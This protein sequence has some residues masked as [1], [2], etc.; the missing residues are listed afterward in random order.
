MLEAHERVLFGEPERPG[1]V[2]EMAELKDWREEINAERRTVKALA[3]GIALGLGL[4]A[5]GILAILAKLAGG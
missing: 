1:I 2:R 4:N 5:A 3:I